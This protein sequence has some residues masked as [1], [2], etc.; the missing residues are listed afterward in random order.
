VLVEQPKCQLLQER[1]PS[2]TH[3]AGEKAQLQEMTFHILGMNGKN[4]ETAYSRQETSVCWK[5]HFN[6]IVLPFFANSSDFYHCF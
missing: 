3:A 5:K 4:A 2:H 6:K 1:H